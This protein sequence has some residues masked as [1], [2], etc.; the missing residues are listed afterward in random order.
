MIH[1]RS[2]RWVPV[3]ALCWIAGS[4]SA[5]SER[6]TAAILRTTVTGEIPDGLDGTLERALRARVT[7][8]GIDL[9]GSVAL[10]LGD[11]QL[12]LGCEGETPTCLDAVATELGARNLLLPNLD[13]AGSQLVLSIA[14]FD[15]D[16]QE[17]R[18]VDRRA[19]IEEAATL[20]DALDGVLGELF[21]GALPSTA[22]APTATPRTIDG[23]S[24]AGASIVM[25]AGVI[26]AAV[27]IALGVA[28]ADEA[29]RYAM[30]PTSTEA[31]ADRAVA[32]YRSASDLALGANVLFTIGGTAL[33]GGAIWLLATLTSGAPAE[34]PVSA[35]VTEGGGGLAIAGTWGQP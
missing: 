31:E 4:A 24:V 29:R 20:L 11:V 19:S 25:G 15:A 3:V 30:Q 13:R 7:A 14:R 21:A 22:S 34:V 6:P 8:L 10:D 9:R 26:A 35:F 23:A 5:Q 17:T 18:R 27:G 2:L 28:S 16:T 33:V 32:L 1:P 12:A